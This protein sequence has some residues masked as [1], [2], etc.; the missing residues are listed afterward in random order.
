M[1]SRG[2]IAQGKLDGMQIFLQSGFKKAVKVTLRLWGRIAKFSRGTI[3]P[4]RVLG[5]GVNG[6][7]ALHCLDMQ[8]LIC[9]RGKKFPF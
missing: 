5:S 6:Y 7:P 1:A 3:G 2:H 4:R 9:S 8:C